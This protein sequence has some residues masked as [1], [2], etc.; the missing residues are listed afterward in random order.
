MSSIARDCKHMSAERC[1]LVLGGGGFVG[2][3]LRDALDARFGKAARIVNTALR[4]QDASALALDISDTEAV[5]A[6]I[7][8]ERPTHICNLAGIAAPAE[9]RRN[10]GLAWELHALA[11][12]RIGHMLREEAPDCWFFHIS[13][14]LVYGKSALKASDV[15]ENARL[16]PIDTYALT[17][18]AGDMAIGVHGSEG[19]KCIRL[20]PFN[21][22]GPGQS[23]QFAVPAFALQIARIKEGLQ[24]PV[25]KVGNLDAVRDFLDVR[26]VAE[27]YTSLVAC[28]D[29]L[30][31]GAIYN[32]ASGVGLSMQRVLEMLIEQSGLRVA[33]EIDPDRQRPSDLPRIVGNADAL[34]RDTGWT[35]RR[36]VQMTLSDIMTHLRDQLK[37]SEG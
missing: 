34:R 7:R 15:D 20:R 17:K 9:A 25:L 27:A 13:S 31:P 10:P 36:S 28:S 18:A 1:I 12:D 30:V 22:T 11:P 32:V 14:G 29:K 16:D 33:I 37:K 21:H 6:M 4:P 26:D 35:A 5:R 19:L 8:R 2:A 23:D 24:E 3:H